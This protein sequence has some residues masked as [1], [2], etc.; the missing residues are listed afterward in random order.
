MANKGR[1]ELRVCR[2]VP[3]EIGFF[4]HPLYHYEVERF[5]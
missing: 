3:R 4:L 2:M 5:A 1:P